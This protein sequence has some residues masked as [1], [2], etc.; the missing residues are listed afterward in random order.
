MRRRTAML[1]SLACCAH[2]Q[3]VTAG[4]VS[5]DGHRPSIAVEDLSD[6]ATPGGIAGRSVA[7]IIISELKA[8]DRF[9]LVDTN[10]ALQPDD[11]VPRFQKWRSENAAWLMTGRIRKTVD[12]RLKIDVR[13]WNVLKAEQA[14]ATQY[15]LASEDL[16]HVSHLIA[17][18]IAQGVTA[19]PS[20]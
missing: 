13:L 16:P 5:A 3:R 7:Q 14:T 12:H 11:V 19:S 17:E 1:L 4:P 9:I 20:E 8:Q 10:H 15:I 6:T 18:D 2:L